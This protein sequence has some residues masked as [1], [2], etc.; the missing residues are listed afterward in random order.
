MSDADPT[1]LDSSGPSRRYAT[2]VVA[3]LSLIVLSCVAFL[4]PV[5]YVTM[6]PGPAFDT[7]GTFDDKPMFTFGKGVTTYPTKG[8]LDFTTVSVT[9]AEADV[10]LA[11]AFDAYFDEDTA[12]V[13]RSFIY[14]QGES[15]KDAKAQGQAQLS[16]SKD[17]SRV[18][19][20]RAAG[21]TVPEV[22]TIDYVGVTASAKGKLEKGDVIRSVNGR[23]TSTAQAVVK[24]VGRVTVGD[25]V[26]IG[27]T[28]G[29]EKKSVDIVTR[30]DPKNNEAAA[31]RGAAAREV[32]LPDQDHQQ[33]R[34]AGR[35]PERRNDVR[36]RH[37]RPA[38]A[39]RRSPA[40]GRWPAPARSR[41]T[42]RSARLVASG[43]RWQERPTAARRSSLYRPPTAPR[44]SRGTTTACSL[45]KISTL[46]TPS[47]RSRP[48][49]RTRRLRCPDAHR[50]ERC[51]APRCAWSPWRSSRT[52]A[53]D[54]WDQ[55]PRLYALVPT[56]EL[57]EHE[58]AL[59]ERLSVSSTP[60]PT[61]SRPSSR[62]ACRPTDRSRTLLAEIEWPE[63][64]AGCAAVVERVMLPPDA[65]DD[66]AR[67]CGRAARRSWRSTPTAAR[68]GWSRP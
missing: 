6:R 45:V 68:S 34:P 54:G 13:P 18:A 27:Y 56:A 30:P 51:P 62:T 38:H 2:L 14:R 23:D 8:S 60:S 39:R 44:R 65:E 25:P 28:R 24:A 3:S 10:S 33:R 7:L 67:R 5:P 57:I 22:P 55:P 15:A 46:T 53:A 48:W 4:V 66:A 37:L 29:G 50:R 43:R 59:A 35:R 42:A 63:A 17:A 64:V 9:R 12:V 32:Q 31:D 11:Q 58:P 40:G 52:S 20:L 47:T 1:V 19:G 16:S 36:P 21:Y 26:T 41:R 61:G 49:R